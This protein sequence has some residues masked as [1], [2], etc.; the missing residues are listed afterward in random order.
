MIIAVDFDDTLRIDGEPNLRLMADLVGAQKNG[1]I[2][3]LWSC[4]TGQR[5][6]DA[7]RFCAIHG[8]RFN[9]VNDNHISVVKRFG[10]NP[11]KIY[12]DIYIDDK[13][14]SY[15]KRYTDN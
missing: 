13:A 12:A 2:V 15:G 1:H 14:I 5:L 7:I 11:R 3:I 6:A 10:Y 4:R 9:C 8:L